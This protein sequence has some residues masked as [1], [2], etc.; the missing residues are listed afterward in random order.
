LFFK[1][2]DIIL[3]RT[4]DHHLGWIAK[5]WPRCEVISHTSRQSMDVVAKRDPFYFSGMGDTFEI[6][7][8]DK[9]SMH[10]WTIEAWHWEID[11]RFRRKDDK[12]S[13]DLKIKPRDAEKGTRQ[14]KDKVQKAS[15]GIGNM[16]INELGVFPLQ[17][18]SDKI[19]AKLRRRGKVFWT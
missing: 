3:E 6:R 8:A 16:N 5:Y 14:Q 7:S 13:F 4:N 1:P 9:V 2:S 11:G 15:A 19:I 17:H 18:A 12:L 10:R